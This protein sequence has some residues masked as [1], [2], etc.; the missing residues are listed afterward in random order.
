MFEGVGFDAPL[1]NSLN[2][3]AET[4]ADALGPLSIRRDVGVEAEEVRGIVLA[5]EGN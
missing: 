3:F 4:Y 2:R 1:E 5:L